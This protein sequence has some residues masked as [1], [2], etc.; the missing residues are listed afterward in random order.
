MKMGK[1]T[2]ADVARLAQVS[3]T[4]AARV[5]HDNGY[6]SEENREQVLRAVKTLGYRPNLQA[7]SLRTQRSQTLG[8][9]YSDQDNPIFTRL[10]D[11]IRKAALTQGYSML[12][13]DYDYVGSSEADGIG[14]FIDRQ[15]DFVIAFHAFDPKS[16]V[17]LLAS[18]IPVIQIERA[19]LP[20]THFIALDPRPGLSQ[21]L[22]A[23]MAQGHRNIGFIGGSETFRGQP[24]LTKE[25]ELQRAETFLA[26]ASQLGLNPDHCPVLTGEYY[27]R[28]MGGRLMGQV[29]ASRMLDGPIPVTAIIAGSDILAAGILHEYYA[30]R[31]RVPDDI[32]LV[33]YDDS[34]AEL[35]CP[36]LA[37]ILQPYD[38][39]AAVAM[40]IVTSSHNGGP[41]LQRSVATRL[42]SRQSIGPAR[43]PT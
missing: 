3:P 18:G 40:E 26:E 23:L 27:A 30:R 11:A 16:Y 41:L 5:V 29:L 35:L 34:I 20:D 19:I 39:I 1:P 2:M 9:I 42:V 31:L 14:Q 22:K 32:S 13:V 43:A 17:Q 24:S 6:V 10:A 33:G 28:D 25:V 15:V 7:R 38:E 4:T 36:Q 8:L 12:S 21:A 37:S